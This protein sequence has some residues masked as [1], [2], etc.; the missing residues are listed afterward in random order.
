MSKPIHSLVVGLIVAST[1][2]AIAQRMTIPQLA[3][4][5]KPKPFVVSRNIEWALPQF[6]VAVA[7]ADLIVQ[8][9]LTK[10]ASYLSND[11]TTLYTDYQ[12]TPTTYIASRTPIGPSRPGPATT[13]LI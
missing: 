3:E 11:E 4:R 5:A 8:G 6:D 7:D 9:T 13:Y 1:S 12:L 2:T 10:V